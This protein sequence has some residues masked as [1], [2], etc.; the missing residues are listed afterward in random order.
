VRFEWYKIQRVAVDVAVAGWQF[1]L[2]R[3]IDFFFRRL[4][5]GLGNGVRVAWGVAVAGW[6]WYRWIEEIGAVILIPSTTC[7]CGCGG[8]WVAVCIYIKT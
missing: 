5:D 2:I 1:V 7:G 3:K 8:G 6:Q 4:P